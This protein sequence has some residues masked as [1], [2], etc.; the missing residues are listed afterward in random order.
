MRLSAT[1]ERRRE[2]AAK[3]GRSGMSGASGIGGAGV[4]HLVVAAAPR[5]SENLP[6]PEEFSRTIAAKVAGL[7]GIVEYGGIAV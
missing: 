5:K 6:L 2:L 1:F 3:A 7:K 4:A